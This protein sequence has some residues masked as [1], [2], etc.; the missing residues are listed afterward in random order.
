MQI[1]HSKNLLNKR[2]MRKFNTCILDLDET[3]LHTGNCKNIPFNSNTYKDFYVVNESLC[4]IFRPH[5]GEFLEYCNDNFENVFIW[6]AGTKP[7]AESIVRLL[8]DRFSLPRPNIVWWRDYC[9]TW[10]WDDFH[11]PVSSYV[12]YA[13]KHM[14]INIDPDDT[15]IID[16]KVSNFIDNKENG[17]GIPAFDYTWKEIEEGK[18][19]K[20]MRLKEIIEWLEKADR[21]KKL[22]EIEKDI[23]K[24]RKQ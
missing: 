11:K 23:F 21:T 19:M 20:D 1:F 6:T 17:I 3:L 13:K 9:Q 24:A 12:E 5:C 7:Y 8:M 22:T 10:G 16:D 4:G 15:I 18:H 14:Y 2:M